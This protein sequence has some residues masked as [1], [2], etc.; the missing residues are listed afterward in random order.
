MLPVKAVKGV[1]T[2]SCPDSDKA[3]VSVPL[4]EGECLCSEE[5]LQRATAHCKFDSRGSGVHCT[6]DYSGYLAKAVRTLTHGKEI[7]GSY[8]PA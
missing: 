4:Y 3:F 1:V 5:I 7:K 8:R 6:P 2:F